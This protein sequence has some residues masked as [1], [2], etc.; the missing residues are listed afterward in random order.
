MA[1]SECPECSAPVS[2]GARFCATCGYALEKVSD[3]SERRQLTVLF[4]D[5]VDSTALSERLDPED[6]NDLLTSHHDA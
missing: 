2:S 3:E 5:I 4:C 6:W 1:P